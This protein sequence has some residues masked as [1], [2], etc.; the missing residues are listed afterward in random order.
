MKTEYV[1]Y[2]WPGNKLGGMLTIEQ[3]K[4]IGREIKRGNKRPLYRLRIREKGSK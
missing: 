3:D 2:V 4:R 1:V